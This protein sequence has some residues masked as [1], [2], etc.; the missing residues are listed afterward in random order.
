MS[1][2]CSWR[3]ERHHLRTSVRGCVDPPAS[4]LTGKYSFR[5][6]LSTM[7]MTHHRNIWLSVPLVSV[8][9]EF[10]QKLP[11]TPASLVLTAKKPACYSARRPTIR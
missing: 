1:R 10:C 9:E 11:D 7:I 8:I 5:T 3:V 6:I 4:R 2:L